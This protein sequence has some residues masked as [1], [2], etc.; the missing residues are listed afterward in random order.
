MKQLVNNYD[1]LTKKNTE[2]IFNKLNDFC[3]KK[4]ESLKCQKFYEKITLQNDGIYQCPYGFNCIKKGNNIYNCI[5]LKEYY[6]NKKMRKKKSVEQK[7]FSLEEIDNMIEIDNENKKYVNNCELLYKSMSDFLHDITKVNKMIDNY[8]K[9]ITKNGLL[10]KDVSKLESIY[11][12]TDFVT[13]RIELYRITSNTEII[14]TGKKRKR[15]AFQLWDIYRH[16]FEDFCR[17]AQL[18]IDMKIYN[19]DHDEES[20]G[21]TDFYANDSITILPYLLIDNAVKYSKHNSVIKIRFYQQD[22][23]LKKITISSLPSYVIVED[24]N[25]FFDRGYRSINNTS[26][27]SGSGLGLDIVK[28]ICDY[29]EIDVKIY[30]E[31]YE[32]E[33]QKFVVLLEHKEVTKND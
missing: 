28:Q 23:M 21:N 12:L 15:N 11:H 27:S 10:K 26:K 4:I 24:T 17:E 29:N 8:S 19:I 30:I 31:D 25:K 5:L 22:G 7:L 32:N 2:G 16:I 9:T 13:K 1:F 14:R 6:S 18:S 33:N 20:N 3:E